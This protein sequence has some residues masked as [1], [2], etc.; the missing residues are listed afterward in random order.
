M[1]LS[2]RI[3]LCSRQIVRQRTESS[4]GRLVRKSVSDLEHGYSGTTSKGEQRVDAPSNLTYTA[5]SSPAAVAGAV[6]QGSP[7]KLGYE[8]AAK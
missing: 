2:A 1:K 7:G 3:R 6:L 4:F 8:D 5:P